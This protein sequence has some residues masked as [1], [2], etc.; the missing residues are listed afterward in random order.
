M[1]K[2]TH[3]PEGLR[4]SIEDLASQE[5]ISRVILGK[6]SPCGNKFQKGHLK[7][8]MD[9]QSGIKINGYTPSGVLEIFATIY[10]VDKRQKVIDYISQNYRR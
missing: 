6:F 7:Y 1:G 8:Q 9:T 10:P 4:D 2:H 3:I 5:Y